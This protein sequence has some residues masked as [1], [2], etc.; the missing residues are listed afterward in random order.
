MVTALYQLPTR[1]SIQME[2]PRFGNTPSGP[3]KQ[4]K[5]YDASINVRFRA[6]ISRAPRL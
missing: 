6:R 3:F 2:S 4:R 5:P 1:N